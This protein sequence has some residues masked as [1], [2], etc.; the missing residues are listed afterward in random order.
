MENNLNEIAWQAS[1]TFSRLNYFN[2]ART[3]GKTPAQIEAERVAFM[4]LAIL[5]QGKNESAH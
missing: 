4:L 5:K 1:K 2:P 3:F